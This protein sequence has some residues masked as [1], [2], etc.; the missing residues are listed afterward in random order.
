MLEQSSKIMKTKILLLLLSSVMVS[1][2]GQRFSCGLGASYDSYVGTY[3]NADALSFLYNPKFEFTCPKSGAIFGVS[4][5]FTFGKYISSARTENSGINSVVAEIPLNFQ[6]GFNQKGPSDDRYKN[7]GIFIGGGLSR[8]IGNGP[9]GKGITMM[10]SY[11]GLKLAPMGRPIELRFN[12][13]KEFSE[14]GC[15]MMRR[16]MGENNNSGRSNFQRFSVAVSYV[17]YCPKSG[18]K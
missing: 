9:G 5:P 18:R 2:Q 6:V 3:A 1:V 8:I 15:P 11:V 14:S 10:N 4:A 7:N 12:Y 17:F 16:A 13:G